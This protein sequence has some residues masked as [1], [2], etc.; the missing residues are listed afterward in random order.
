MA[1]QGLPWTP[2]QRR[3]TSSIRAD[4]AEGDETIK[5]LNVEQESFIRETEDLRQTI[6]EKELYLKAELIKKP[7]DIVIALSCQNEII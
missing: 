5:K 7:P 4:R 2:H 3:H 1:V 6:Y